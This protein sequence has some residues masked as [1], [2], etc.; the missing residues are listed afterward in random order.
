[1][2]SVATL[3]V[4]GQEHTVVVEP[5]DTLVDVLRGKV[6]LTGTKKGCGVGD[7][8]VCTVL[9]DGRPMNAC[10]L[11]AADIADRRITTI[12]G[13]ACDGQLTSLQKS[14]VNE[15]GIQCGFCTP[16]M[17]L[18]ATA[19]LDRHANPTADEIKDALAGNLCRCTG[20]SGIMRAV[21]RCGNYHDNGTCVKKI[22]SLGE[23]QDGRSD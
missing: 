1:M 15:G 8:G 12:E 3:S 6:R 7:C 19:L 21:S 18:S 14:F 13:V 4:N 16:G 22:H 11:L 17:V 23:K 9:I 20:Y 5:Y 2:S 10:L